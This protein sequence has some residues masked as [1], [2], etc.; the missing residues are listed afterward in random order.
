MGTT[1]LN[2]KSC[3]RCDM[4]QVIICLAYTAGDLVWPMEEGPVPLIIL[5]NFLVL[6]DQIHI[7][8]FVL[9]MYFISVIHMPPPQALG[10]ILTTNHPLKGIP[11]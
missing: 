5:T 1:S 3:T 4:T 10:I 6:L 11:Y 2:I 7:P 8:I 9:G